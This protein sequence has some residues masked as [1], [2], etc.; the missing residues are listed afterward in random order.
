[1]PSEQ[2][3][4]PLPCRVCWPPQARGHRG[5]P[6]RGG[7]EGHREALDAAKDA[8][9]PPLKLVG[10]NSEYEI[11]AARQYGGVRVLGLETREWGAEAEV[12]SWPNAR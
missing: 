3:G 8:A 10:S 6:S 4:Y 12:Q 2:V 9:G 7:A 1:M 5:L 11:G